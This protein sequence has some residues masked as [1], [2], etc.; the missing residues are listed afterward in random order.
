MKFAVEADEKGGPVTR[1][2]R[3][4][5][6]FVGVPFERDIEAT[7]GAETDDLA[8]WPCCRQGGQKL[9]H[10]DVVPAVMALQEH[11]GDAGSAAE[12]TI[13][14][15]RRVCIEQIRV[16]SARVALLGA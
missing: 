9:Q 7:S 8:R 12:V 1:V 5:G 13:Y 2:N 4:C 6:E 16:K 14:L 11:F 15:E 3:G 10:V